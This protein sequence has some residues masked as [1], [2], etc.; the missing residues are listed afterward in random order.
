MEKMFLIWVNS[1]QHPET[2]IT[3]S[4]RIRNRF[5]PE[6]QTV[7][8]RYLRETV[9]IRTVS[10]IW[11]SLMM[12]RRSWYGSM[13]TDQR[14]TWI[15]H[16]CMHLF[17]KTV[18][19]ANRRN[20]MR[21]VV[22]MIIRM[23]TQMERKHILYGRELHSHYHRK[24]HWQMPWKPQICI[25]SHIQMGHLQNL[26]WSETAKTLH[27]KWCRELL[28]MAEKQLLYGWKT[29]QMIRLWQKEQTISGLHA[30]RAMDGKKKL[31]QKEPI[32][33]HLWI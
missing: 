2:G 6:L 33:L 9:L 17:T 4:Q 28:L 14:T 12:E 21:Q 1:A 26:S 32:L 22:W 13:M 8:E 18:N 25:A 19:G 11:Q 5:L 16:L 27:M 3:W 24:P 23:C 20:Y 7:R 29:V 10:R 30:A 31:W 15:K